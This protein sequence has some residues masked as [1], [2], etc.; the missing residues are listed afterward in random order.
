MSYE[1]Q[2]SW[3][4]RKVRECLER[5]GGVEFEENR[6]VR[7]LPILGMDTPLAYRNKA[8]FP[9][10]RD[11]VGRIVTGFYAGHSHALIPSDFCVI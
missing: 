3:K 6:G 7:F 2:L 1:A 8:Q 11:K 4:E 10:G 9:V 5:I